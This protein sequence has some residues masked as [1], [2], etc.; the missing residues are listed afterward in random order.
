MCFNCV[1]MLKFTVVIVSE[2]VVVLSA[3]IIHHVPKK[4]RLC[5]LVITSANE[6]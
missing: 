5:F 2:D 3:G 4:Q 6:H 1:Y